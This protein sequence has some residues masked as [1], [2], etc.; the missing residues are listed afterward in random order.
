MQQAHELFEQNRV[1]MGDSGQI[2]IDGNQLLEDQ[3]LS[4]TANDPIDQGDENLV[5]YSGVL[6]DEEG[7]DSRRKSNI[8]DNYLKKSPTKKKPSQMSKKRDQNELSPIHNRIV[9]DDF[10]DKK[11]EKTSPSRSLILNNKKSSDFL[12]DDLVDDAEDNSQDKEQQEREDEIN[13]NA[14]E[15]IK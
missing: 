8:L 3:I 9:F 15:Q 6:S 5:E 4:K 10:F 7:E 11:N 2:I 1:E 14:F 13:Q 12:F